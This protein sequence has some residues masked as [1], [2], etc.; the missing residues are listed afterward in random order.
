MATPPTAE[1]IAAAA[2]ASPFRVGPAMSSSADAAELRYREEIEEYPDPPADVVRFI[3]RKE[4]VERLE[5]A[6][7]V[8]QLEP[9]GTIVELG[10]GTCWLSAALARRPA[11]ER[12][13][14]VEFSRRR[15]ELLA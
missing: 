13:I 15:L 3:E 5:H 12:V 14:A 6:L 9:A 8:A 11:V 10:A 4:L 2:A 7:A 1:A